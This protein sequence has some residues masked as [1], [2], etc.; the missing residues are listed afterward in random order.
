[1]PVN[2]AVAVD[3]DGAT[4]SLYEPGC[5][6]IY[7]KKQ[8]RWH[9]AQQADYDLEQS[10]GMRHMRAKMAEIVQLLS[11]CSQV[12]VGLSVT[13]LPYFELEKAGLS[14]WEF[15]GKPVEFL[16]YILAQE[17]EAALEREQVKPVVVP[18]PQ[19]IEEGYFLIS[20]KEIQENNTGVTT[21]QVLLPFVRKGEFEKLE[22][23]C[24]HI[25]PWLEAEAAQGNCVCQLEKLSPK[26]VKVT[27]TK[28]N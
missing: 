18:V 24:N 9:I 27:I 6:V 11:A 26:D 4:T 10:K 15:E 13:G 25:P 19:Q 22:I 12:F 28:N 7:Q 1:M 20:I 14:I 8:G 23:L 2:I 17:E 5:L 3:K 16:D 21:K